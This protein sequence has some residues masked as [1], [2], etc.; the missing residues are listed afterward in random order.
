MVPQR[1]NN[2]GTENKLSF[3][4]THPSGTPCPFADDRLPVDFLNTCCSC[5]TARAVEN[6]TAFGH[7][8]LAALLKMGLENEKL[9]YIAQELRQAASLLR[10]QYVEVSDGHGSRRGGVRKLVTNE[11]IPWSRPD[12]ED[13][14]ASIHKVADWYEKVGGLGFDVG[15]WY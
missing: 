4:M 1:Q 6:L 5:S 8:A 12:F 14:L 15:V 2:L 7:N 9:P 13:A 11:F 10:G 3:G